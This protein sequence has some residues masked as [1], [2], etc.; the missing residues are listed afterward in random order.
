MHFYVSQ[1]HKDY[2]DRSCST[3]RAGESGTVVTLT[4]SKQQKSVWGLTSRAGVTPKSVSVTSLSTD[5]MR[6][7]GTQEPSGILYV[8]PIL[9]NKE[10]NRRTRKPRPNLAQ[11]RRRSRWE[12]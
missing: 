11:L 12:Q 5:L 6:I 2:L 3:V 8:A 10:P 1:D 9:E 7:I 4:T